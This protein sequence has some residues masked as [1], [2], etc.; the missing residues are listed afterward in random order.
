MN[1]IYSICSCI[2]TAVCLVRGERHHFVVSAQPPL[3]VEGV[4]DRRSA[5][6]SEDG[7]ESMFARARV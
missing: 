1:D 2:Y 6:V 3:S 7:A 5:V 4:V